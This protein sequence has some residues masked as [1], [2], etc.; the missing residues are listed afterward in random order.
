MPDLLEALLDVGVSIGELAL[1]NGRYQLKGTVSKALIT[2]KAEALGALIQAHVTY[3]NSAY[4]ELA[5]R[6]KGGSLSND[7]EKIGDLVAKV[8]TIQA[9]LI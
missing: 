6:L 1:I 2:E 8:S 7:H 4:R 5:H 3:Y 9:P